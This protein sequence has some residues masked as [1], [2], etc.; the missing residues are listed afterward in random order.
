MLIVGYLFNASSKMLM[1]CR[2]KQPTR[3]VFLTFYHK[4]IKLGFLKQVENDAHLT[5]LLNPVLRF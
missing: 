4:Q 2:L 3:N 5:F 1:S